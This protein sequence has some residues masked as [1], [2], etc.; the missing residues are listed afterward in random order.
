MGI[1]PQNIF[2]TVDNGW[3][4]LGAQSVLKGGLGR[5]PTKEAL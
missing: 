1:P 3:V 4:L 2:K 5:V